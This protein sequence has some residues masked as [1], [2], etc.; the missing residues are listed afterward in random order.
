MQ[1]QGTGHG[2]VAEDLRPATHDARHQPPADVHHAR[3][4]V[5]DRALELG[6]LDPDP[7]HDGRVGSDPESLMTASAPMITGP[8]IT[9]DLTTA[10][11]WIAVRPSKWLP[12]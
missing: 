11:G 2:E 4:G 3:V 10:V 1:A 6:A 12:S 7:L 5:Y 9:L 8:T